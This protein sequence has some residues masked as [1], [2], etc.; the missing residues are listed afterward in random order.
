MQTLLDYTRHCQLT[1]GRNYVYK[2]QGDVRNLPNELWEQEHCIL[3]YKGAK[4][5]AKVDLPL[6]ESFEPSLVDNARES[7]E[8]AVH[9]A[10]LAAARQRGARAA[11]RPA[12]AAD[13]DPSQAPIDATL[14]PAI[15]N[16]PASGQRL[17]Y[18]YFRGVGTAAG[19]K[20]L[21]HDWR[22]AMGVDSDALPP[23]TCGSGSL[24]MKL[25]QATVYSQ[26]RIW[27]AA[28]G[29]GASFSPEASPKGFLALHSTG[30]G[31]TCLA[32]AV[33]QAFW[34]QTLPSGEPRPLMLFTT[35]ANR[36]RLKGSAGGKSTDTVL[37]YNCAKQMFPS[38]PIAKMSAAEF[39]KRVRPYS[40]TQAGNRLKSGAS[41]D[42]AVFR[43]QVQSAVIVID[44]AQSIFA[45]EPQFATQAGILRDWLLS[46]DS[47]GATV[48]IMTATPGRTV[49]ELFELLNSLRRSREGRLKPEH[50]AAEDGT[51]AEARASEFR[52]AMAGR[53]S[54]VDY[55]NN[56][57][58]YP[59][60]R[61]EVQSTDMSQAQR[62][63]WMD[64]VKKAKGASLETAEQWGSLEGKRVRKESNMAKSNFQS[65]SFKSGKA[66]A[67]YASGDLRELQQYSTKLVRVVENIEKE[68]GKK[69]FL[70]SAFK[71]GGVKQIA[72]VLQGRGWTNMYHS[73]RKVGDALEHFSATQSKE[74]L[75][76]LE[77][78]LKSLP[79]ESGKRY[80]STAD[81]GTAPPASPARL[82]GG[83]TRSP[84]RSP[85]RAQEEEEPVSP[86]E[87][88]RKSKAET[89]AQTLAML[90]FNCLENT[91]GR[92]V[93]LLLATDKYNEGLDLKSVRVMHMFEPQTSVAAERQMEGRGRRYCSHT[94]L[95]PAER[96]V[97]VIHYFSELGHG[98]TQE[99]VNEINELRAE[100][101][102][103]EGIAESLLLRLRQG[104]AEMHSLVGGAGLRAGSFGSALYNWLNDRP[105]LPSALSLDSMP[106]VT[107]DDVRLARLA[108]V[109]ANARVR[110]LQDRRAAVP[111]QLHVEAANAKDRREFLEGL[112]GH[113]KP[114]AAALAR[115]QKR[116][117]SARS[118]EE[119]RRS[120]QE[121]QAKLRE[122]EQEEERS[123]AAG[124]QAR[125]A[126]R[127]LSAEAKT[128]T[129]ALKR[130][131]P[132]LLE[133]LN[134]SAGS[135]ERQ[136]DTGVMATDLLVHG[137]ARR[138]GAPMKSFM[139]ALADSATDCM[140]LEAL[141]ARMGVN[142]K[143][144]I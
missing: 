139:Q 134:E 48:V 34:S 36:D 120:A 70:Y 88:D 51:V 112:R 84:Q 113:S 93:N 99:L 73:L 1:Y 10:Q 126:A 125:A 69:Q 86:E 37:Y 38:S 50:F 96:D 121:V 18:N 55:R 74:A 132:A 39:D 85:K 31:K 111:V 29:S 98:N 141:H 138:E 102:K 81:W 76:K 3:Y 30:S 2:P 19:S 12:R 135:V 124:E 28:Q 108:E 83:A 68:K 13:F 40:F 45:P 101:R 20:D 140:V 9:L 49:P 129:E 114:L 136:V 107:D 44:E 25:H 82:R 21:Q 144:Q 61:T 128:K 56:T 119:Q 67:V 100:A 26:M 54:Y 27:A 77:A 60:M 23:S 105:Q 103:Q 130:I 109:H 97:Q 72:A 78:V 133:L 17:L 95:P 7:D 115:L 52:R 59:V 24:K 35:P 58:D 123:M 6:W 131:D 53:V 8:V 33:Y 46:P 117:A 122:L 15:L 137:V 64:K 118:S 14:G 66:S 65:N 80:V 90:V 71:E 142:V 62:G 75:D 127:Q 41:K 143:C 11:A 106:S 110:A 32:S 4:A 47:N 22:E 92:I 116:A 57:N 91:R 16:S 43:R 5:K 42:A 104:R 94:D 87:Q 63:E 89:Q 79:G